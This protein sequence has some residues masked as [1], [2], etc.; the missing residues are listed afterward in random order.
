MR[1]AVHRANVKRYLAN[2]LITPCLSFLHIRCAG[3]VGP[4]WRQFPELTRLYMFASKP[5]IVRTSIY[6]QGLLAHNAENRGDFLATCAA[7]ARNMNEV[8]IHI[9]F[10]IRL[11]GPFV[12]LH[13]TLHLLT[14][15]PA[16]N[17]RALQCLDN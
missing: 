10:T 1:R 17:Y 6:L 9:Q 13:F 15:P 2:C 8:H 11:T 12:V 7:H 5:N 3:N 14:C 16:E 4:L